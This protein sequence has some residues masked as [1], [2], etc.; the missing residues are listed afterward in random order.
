VK[1]KG[2][3]TGPKIQG[4]E[5]RDQQG[6]RREKRQDSPQMPADVRGRAE[7]SAVNPFGPD[8]VEAA[9]DGQEDHDR[10]Q[11]KGELAAHQVETGREDEEAHQTFKEAKETSRSLVCF[12]HL[13][14]LSA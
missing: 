12:R 1:R 6:R 9:A 7:G 5:S 10:E 4:R 14:G 11:P 13:S 2:E 8:E 3:E